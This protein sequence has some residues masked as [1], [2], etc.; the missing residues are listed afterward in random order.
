[1]WLHVK[2][3]ML[4]YNSEW[5]IEWIKLQLMSNKFSILVIV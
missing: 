2:Y 1:M 4:F 5:Q 3:F